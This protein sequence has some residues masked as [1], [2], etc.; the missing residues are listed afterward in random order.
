MSAVVELRPE[1]LWCPAGGF[2]VDPWRPVERAFLTH[3]HADHARPGSGHYVCAAAGLAL[4]RRRLGAGAR[5]DG[6]AYGERLRVGGATVSLHPAGHV[7]GSAQVRIE[8]D[9][10]VWVL[11]GDYKLEPDPTAAPFESVPCD[12][13]LSECTFGLPI[14]RWEPSERVAAEILAWWQ[15]CADAGRAALLGVYALGKA[16]R[17]LAELMRALGGDT[18]SAPGAIGA[19]GSVRALCDEYRASGVELPPLERAQDLPARGA[20][21]LILAPPASLLAP[22]ARRFVEP[23]T[24][25]VSGWARVR[26][27]L[28]RRR[29]ERGFVLSDHADW[30]GLLS[31]IEG[32]GA[33]RV[34]LTHGAHAPLARWLTEQGREASAL[35]TEFRGEAGAEHAEEEPTL[36]EEPAGERAP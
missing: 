14:Y 13:F 6:L 33:E 29:V 32:S 18:G 4:A 17:V 12:V 28:G 1:G 10:E 20:G 22:F 31:A 9:G 21:A 35:A 3:A 30:P 7:L 23:S 15:E 8:V 11:S 26:G 36:G 27:V 25:L 19:H 24:A 16:Q 2:H 5:I 34:L